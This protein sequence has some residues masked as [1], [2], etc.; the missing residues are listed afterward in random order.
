MALDRRYRVVPA[1]ELKLV[2]EAED[3][4]AEAEDNRRRTRSLVQEAKAEGYR[5]GV[6]TALA[7]VRLECASA[8]SDALRRADAALLNLERPLVSLVI[9]VTQKLIGSIPEP[10]RI[11]LLAK[12]ALRE[13]NYPGPAILYVP[14]HAEG[15]LREATDTL[16][17]RLEII[18]DPLL[19]EDELVIEMLGNRTHIGLAN[20]LARVKERLSHE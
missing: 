19:K 2:R 17:P 3:L 7:D 11:T 15:P 1:K 6:E 20:Q 9:S 8:V 4:L 12:Q 16:D 5:H 13:T 18:A 10:D 14:P